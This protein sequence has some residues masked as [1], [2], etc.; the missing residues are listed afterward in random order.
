MHADHDDPDAG[1]GR[2]KL[3]HELDAAFVRKR[4]VHHGQIGAKPQ[5]LPQSLLGAAGLAGHLEG[6]IAA[7]DG[8]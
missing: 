3:P 5:G 1:Q 7:D 8:F 4:D 6:R 2:G